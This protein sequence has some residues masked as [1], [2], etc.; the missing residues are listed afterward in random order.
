MRLPRFEQPRSNTRRQA[1]RRELVHDHIDHL[2]HACGDE[3]GQLEAEVEARRLHADDGNVGGG[4]VEQPQ[5][6]QHVLQ[7]ELVRRGFGPEDRRDFVVREPDDGS[8]RAPGVY[9]VDKDQVSRP[10]MTSSR[11]IPQVPPSRI[12]TPSG[13]W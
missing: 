3:R 2:V 4:S 5:E 9:G 10:A 1:D 6:R 11:S 7:A 12:S 13:T 8:G